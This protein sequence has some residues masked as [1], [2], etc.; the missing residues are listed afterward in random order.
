MPR[1]L[2]VTD[3]D[4][5][6]IAA[7]RN[8]RE[9]DLVGRQDGFIAEGEIV[10]RLLVETPRH[11]VVSVLI[12]E[13]RQAKL[14]PVL[15]RL[16]GDTPVF[17]A[18]Q[19]VIDAIAGFHLH[20][21]IL[22][23]GR[24]SAGPGAEALLRT[25]PARA[26]VVAAVGIANHDNVG[27]IFRNAAAFGAHAVLLDSGSCDPLYRKAIRVSVGASLTVPFARFSE[28]ADPVT[29]LTSQGFE[30]FAL[31]PSGRVALRNLRR[32]ERVAV[33]FGAEGS[34]LPENVL[35]RTQ[36]VRIPMARGFDSLNVATASG[37]V[38]HHFADD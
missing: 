8:V 13:K 32:P 21:G 31:S 15:A 37:I 36:T 25:L 17:T 34:G 5:P 7:F 27:G 24:R 29:L 35:A 23:L 4:D 20:R 1:L 2:P 22:A 38:L 18:T 19:E 11:E 16:P 9:R 12:A 14:G 30:V 33:L 10:L 3:P 28:G 26:L 6:R